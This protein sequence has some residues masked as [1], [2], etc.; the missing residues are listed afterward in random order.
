MRRVPEV[1]DTWFDSGS[2]P[3]AIHSYGGGEAQRGEPVKTADFIGEAQ[4]QTRAWFYYMHVL[5]V[6]L[7]D[8]NVFKNCITTGIVLAE[9]GKK[10]SKKLKNYPDPVQ[11][12]EKY[13]ADAMRLY[14]LGSPVVR[15]ESLNFSEKGV[16][17]IL[18]KNIGRLINVLA[19]YQLY[20]NDTARDWKSDN[21]LDR[22][23]LAR[24]DQMIRESESGY[25]KYELDIATRPIAGFIDDL[26]VWYVRRSRDRFKEDGDDKAK[27][28]AT[29]RYVLHALSRAL[30]PSMPFVAEYVFQAVREN[31]DEESVHLAE[32]PKARATANFLM[33]FFGADNHDEVLLRAMQTART[34]VSSGLEARDKA[35][36]RVRQPLQKIVLSSALL[37]GGELETSLKLVIAEELNVKEVVVSAD[38]ETGSV[39]LDT[40]ITDQ[41]REEGVVRDT[42]RTIQ[43]FRKEKNLKPGEATIYQISD[44]KER[45]IIEKHRAEIERETNTTITFES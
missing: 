16:D 23:I 1:L 41:L 20:A 36:I 28:L 45:V 38:I 25:E 32:W 6:A 42:I 26:S 35:G 37:E 30:A 18:K 33:Q 4:D 12:I 40:A 7:F 2:A 3:F 44:S 13:G 24:L 15:A 21:I 9:D 31:E 27:A 43:A 10:M 29:L 8:T 11:M 17:E 22:W 19:F 39:H 14:M 5:G 34:I